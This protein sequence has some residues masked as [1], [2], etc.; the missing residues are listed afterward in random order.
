MID[1]LNAVSPIFYCFLIVSSI[2]FGIS[3]AVS[4]W[5]YKTIDKIRKESDL[6]YK[7]NITDAENKYINYNISKAKKQYSSLVVKKKSYEKVLRKNKLR[8]LFGLKPKTAEFNDD[9]KE[10]IIEL[11]KG[12]SKPFSDVGGEGRGYL[13]FTKNEIFSL[14][15]T[16]AFRLD[17]ILSNSNVSFIKNVK[18][19]FIA[20]GL[21]LYF[22]YKNLLEKTFAVICFKLID[23]FVW[24]FR[25]FSPVS[26][27]KYFI[28]NFTADSLSVLICETVIE[29]IGEEL[30]VVYKT[31]RGKGDNSHIL[32]KDAG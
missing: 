9:F 12:V 24:F 20:S 27:G 7:N 22:N 8:K 4:L 15:K 3:F 6:H 21:D 11:A 16:V 1:F 25:V 31:S 5:L 29:L 28:K 13:S 2:V 26:M 17:E 10:I 32:S 18:I 23:F 14:L 30:A 19:S